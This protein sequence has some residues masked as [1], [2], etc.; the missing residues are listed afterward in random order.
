MDPDIEPQSHWEWEDT[1]NDDDYDGG[2]AP[3]W[4]L[5]AKVAKEDDEANLDNVTNDMN[6]LLVFVR[7]PSSALPLLCASSY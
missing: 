4:S 6:T 3:L 5:Y 1:Y 2:A 7:P